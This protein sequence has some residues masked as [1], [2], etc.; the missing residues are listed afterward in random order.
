M[1]STHEQIFKAQGAGGT[2]LDSQRLEALLEQKVGELMRDQVVA[3]KE[4]HIELLQGELSKQQEVQ[5]EVVQQVEKMER[6][7]AKLKSTSRTSTTSKKRDSSPLGKASAKKAASIVRKACAV[8]VEIECQYCLL[9]RSQIEQGRLDV[10]ALQKLNQAKDQELATA[11][12][13]KRKVQEQAQMLEMK[14]QDYGRHLK[15]QS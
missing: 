4:R 8:Q 5:Q 7:Y 2:P 15:N 6:Q 9:M 13:Q 3:E 12:A 1:A 14:I 10:Q 11:E